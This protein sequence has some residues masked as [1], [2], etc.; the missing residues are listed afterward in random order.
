MHTAG[1][2]VTGLVV[3]I[4]DVTDPSRLDEGSTDTV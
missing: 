1:R 4:L 3:Q 2:Q